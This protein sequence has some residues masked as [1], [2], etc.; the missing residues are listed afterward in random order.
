ME[1]NQIFLLPTQTMEQNF[2]LHKRF[3]LVFRITDIKHNIVGIPVITKYIPL[4]NILKSRI[5]IKD[6][7]TKLSNTSLTFFRKK[8]TPVFQIFTQNRSDNK[9]I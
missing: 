4:L 2:F 3:E 5:Q 7:Y 6:K 8:T 1:K 9:S